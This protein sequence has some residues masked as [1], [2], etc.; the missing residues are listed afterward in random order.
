LVAAVERKLLVI[1]EAATTTLSFAQHRVRRC[2]VRLIFTGPA[3]S[4]MRV[5]K[6]TAHGPPALVK[7]LTPSRQELNLCEYIDVVEDAPGQSARVYMFRRDS[8]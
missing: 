8:I 5:Y 6:S 2:T 4:W 1:S 3:P 7:S